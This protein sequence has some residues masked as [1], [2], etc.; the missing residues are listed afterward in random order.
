MVS[1]LAP[2]PQSQNGCSAGT[3]PYALAIWRSGDLCLSLFCLLLPTHANWN[4]SRCGQIGLSKSALSQDTLLISAPYRPYHPYHPSGRLV[5]LILAVSQVFFA[6]LARPSRRDPEANRPRS[7]YCRGRRIL[8]RRYAQIRQPVCYVARYA[9]FLDR[10]NPFTDRRLRLHSSRNASA[11]SRPKTPPSSSQK[12]RTSDVGSASRKSGS[13]L[14]SPPLKS[15]FNFLSNTNSDWNVEDPE[16]EDEYGYEDDDG[17]DFGLPSLSNMKRRTRRMAAAAQGQSAA[18]KSQPSLDSSL[19][20][21]NRR[22]SDSADIAIER[23][24][25]VYPMPKKSEGKILRPQYKDIL[26]GQLL[27]SRMLHTSC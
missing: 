19:G 9:A 26:K 11:S 6:V 18:S 15:Y 4:D 23:P 17:D 14:S 10:S 7:E 3:S 16:G 22:Y 2:E 12:A 24:A 20:L 5:P 8:P 13:S 1:L 25:L 21:S 27:I